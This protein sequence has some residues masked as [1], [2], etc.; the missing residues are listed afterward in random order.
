MEL[1]QWVRKNNERFPGKFEMRER[2]QRDGTHGFQ[3]TAFD[4]KG[5][6]RSLPEKQEKVR[7]EN[8]SVSCINHVRQ[9]Y[10]HAKTHGGCAS[11]R[12]LMLQSCPSVDNDVMRSWK[13]DESVFHSSSKQS[14]RFPGK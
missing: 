4:I 7:I 8:E 3:A 11:V 10:Q 12:C 9:V 6:S 14:D 13:E 2:K 5:K 1:K